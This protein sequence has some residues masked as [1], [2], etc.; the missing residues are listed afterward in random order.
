MWTKLEKM[1]CDS[2]NN[3]EASKI[4]YSINPIAYSYCQK[5]PSELR[6]RRCKQDGKDFDCE[7]MLLV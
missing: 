1:T 6:R 3:Q 4:H 2:K 7:A 5:T